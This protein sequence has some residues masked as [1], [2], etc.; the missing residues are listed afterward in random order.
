VA[1]DCAV[2]AGTC[3]LGRCLTAYCSDG[4]KDFDETDVD[5]GGPSC[6]TKC[7]LN[8][9]C[10]VASDCAVGAGT[11]LLGRCLNAYCSDGAKDY[12]ETGLD[13]GGP[14]C[15]S[16]C[17]AGQGCSQGS[18]CTSGSCVSGLCQ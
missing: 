1:N 13:C 3:L 4:T 9:R 7:G 15:T 14:S 6:S 17:P 12:D 10:H 16:K 2:G 11:C 8:Q 18:D 5:C